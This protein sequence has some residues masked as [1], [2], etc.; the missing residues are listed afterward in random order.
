MDAVKKITITCPCQGL[1]PGRS[2]CSPLLYQLVLLFAIY[3]MTLSVILSIQEMGIGKGYGRQHLTDFGKNHN[4]SK[5]GNA[6]ITNING[7]NI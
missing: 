2:A 7:F 4:C 3:L 6:P 5:E 1:N